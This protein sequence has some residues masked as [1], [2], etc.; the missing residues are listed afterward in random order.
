MRYTE[1]LLLLAEPLAYA[2][3]LTF[4]RQ[5]RMSRTDSYDSP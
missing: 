3:R 2:T 4:C 5:G 1:D